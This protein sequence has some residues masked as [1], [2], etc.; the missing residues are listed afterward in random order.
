MIDLPNVKEN[1]LTLFNLT[2]ITL[3]VLPPELMF[4]VL[5]LHQKNINPDGT[6]NFSRIDNAHLTINVTDNTI[7][8]TLNSGNAKIRVYATNY[9]ILRIMSGMG[10]LA[11]SN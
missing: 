8:S 9:N 4:T 1:T 5:H 2:N 10:G 3:I 7:S 6:C 11:Y